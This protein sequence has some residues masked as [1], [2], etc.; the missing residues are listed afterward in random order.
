MISWWDKQ[1]QRADH[2]VSRANG[3][4]ELLTFYAHLLRAQKDTM[5][6]FVVAKRGFRPVTLNSIGLC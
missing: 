3:S 4:K 6:F 1:I 2:L 5:N